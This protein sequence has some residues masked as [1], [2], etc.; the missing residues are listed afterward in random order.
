MQRR[1]TR[2]Y[3]PFRNS[4][5]S[6]L[7]R[8]N[9][10]PELRLQVAPMEQHHRLLHRNSSRDRKVPVVRSDRPIARLRLTWTANRDRHL[11]SRPTAKSLV[12]SVKQRERLPVWQQRERVRLQLLLAPLP[13]H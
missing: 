12:T 2:L 13:V 9:L 8:P 6:R 4:T 11:S 10:L 1:V 7:P 5:G 3:R